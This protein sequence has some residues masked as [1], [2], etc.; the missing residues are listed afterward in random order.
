MK[1]LQH[2]LKVCLESTLTLYIGVLTH[3]KLV[4]SILTEKAP[5]TPLVLQ[6]LVEQS[7]GRRI[8]FEWLRRLSTLIA[9]K[10]GIDIPPTLILMDSGFANL[11]YWFNNEPILQQQ[12]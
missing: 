2:D 3:F 9:L 1:V 10:T 6:M 12:L 5:H 4:E 11:V 8:D 7:C